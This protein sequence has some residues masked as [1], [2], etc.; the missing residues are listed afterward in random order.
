MGALDVQIGVKRDAADNIVAQLELAKDS[1]VGLQ[2]V[3]RLRVVEIGV[4][5]DG[6]TITSCVVEEV[7]GASH[8]TKAAKLTKA[9][10][11]ALRALG[12]AIADC[13]EIPPVSN[14][15]PPGVRTVTVDRWREY[16]YRM[17]IST[18][19]EPRAKQ[20]AFKAGS[21]TLVAAGHVAIWEPHVWL[22][23]A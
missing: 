18:S 9:A 14:H 10:T 15:I 4:D 12:R 11:T 6:D 21:D 17:G 13:G 7:E 1:E 23:K 5:K 3:S 2:F 19:D 22:A 16:A 8:P 20:K